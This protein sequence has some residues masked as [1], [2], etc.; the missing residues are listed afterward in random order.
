[1]KYCQVK[2]EQLQFGNHLPIF[3]VDKGCELIYGLQKTDYKP[4]VEELNV[5]V[6]SEG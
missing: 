4:A 5:V 2:T 1:M 3:P 6:D